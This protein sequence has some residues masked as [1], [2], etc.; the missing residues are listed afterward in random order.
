MLLILLLTLTFL[1]VVPE[2][3]KKAVFIVASAFQGTNLSVLKSLISKAHLSY[4]VLITSAHVSVHH[5]LKWGGTKDG[6]DIEAFQKLEEEILQWM[7]NLVRMFTTHEY[8]KIITKYMFYEQ[9]YTAEIFNYP[10]CTIHPTQGLFLMP[11]AQG[12]HSLL[13]N[14]LHYINEKLLLYSKVI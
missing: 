10:L 11:S 7:G 1:Q 14:D 5:H 9:N 12:A 6:H 2:N 13:P 8:L 4:C 3:C